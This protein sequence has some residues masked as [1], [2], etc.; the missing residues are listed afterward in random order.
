MTTH[1]LPFLT[2]DERVAYLGAKHYLFGSVP[3]EAARQRLD[4]LNFH[5]FLGYARN[6]RLLGSRQQVPTDNTLDRILTIVDLDRL[7]SVEIFHA[8]RK[9]EWRLRALLVEHHCAMFTPTQCYLD[10]A[11]YSVHNPSLPP[12]PEVLTKH[13]TRSREPYVLEHLDR[14]LPVASLPV[15][16]V[17]DTWSL[18]ALSRVICESIPIAGENGLGETR[19]WKQVAGSVGVSATTIMVKLHAMSVLRNLVAHHS[20]LWMRP[21]VSTPKLPKVFP[22]SLRNSI[23][24]KSMYGVLLTLAEFLGPHGEGKAFLDEVDRILDC[25]PAFRL[26]LTRPLSKNESPAQKTPASQTR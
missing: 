13:I 23:D 15:W 10:A 8:L 20:R 14:G 26:G 3:S 22:A 25:D 11:H 19:L 6:Y 12:L 21:T 5:Y 9:I 17:V 18:S 2:L 4:A 16:A 24:P 1:P 7:L